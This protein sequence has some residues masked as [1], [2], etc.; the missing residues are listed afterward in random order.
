[1]LAQTLAEGMAGIA[2][3]QLV[4]P[5]CPVVLGSFHTT[6][7]PRSGALTLGTPEANLA[8]M[9]LAQL[10]RR[11]GVPVRSGGGQIT[12]SN[13]ADGQAM[14]DSAGAMWATIL[15]GANQVRNL[16]NLPPRIIVVR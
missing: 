4:R 3:A 6:M 16:S 1:M 12:S 14:Q 5:G 2:L 15:A 7:N 11:L 10:G 9:A 8:T 13:S